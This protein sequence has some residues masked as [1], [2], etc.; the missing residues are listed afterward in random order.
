MK[1]IQIVEVPSADVILFPTKKLILR[2]SERDCLRTDLK[3]YH[4]GEKLSRQLWQAD[5]QCRQYR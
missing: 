1:R 2:N 3:K 5:K 4:V